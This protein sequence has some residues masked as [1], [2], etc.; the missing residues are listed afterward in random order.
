M[1]QP[2]SQSQ[3]PS[4][5]PTSSTGGGRRRLRRAGIAVAAGTALIVP[6]AFAVT[7]DH[8]D[9]IAE[10]L[11]A[12]DGSAVEARTVILLIGDGTGDSEITIAR[13]YAKGAAGQLALDTLPF[14]GAMTTYSVQQD[15][16]ELP[17]YV[18]D[19]AS[20]ATAW[21]TGEQTYNGAISVLPD[22][23]PT[24]TL[25]QLAAQQ[26]YLTGVVTTSEIQDAT[27]AVQYSHVPAR[28]CLGPDSMERC[29]DEDARNGGPGSISEQ[30]V[31]SDA[32]LI[33]GGGKQHLDQRIRGGADAGSTSWQVAQD[34]GFDTITTARELRR[35]RGDQPVLGVFGSGNLDLEWTGPTP[36]ATGTEP[37]QCQI[38]GAR[39]RNQPRLAEL[40][41]T[42]LDILHEQ[43]NLENADADAPSFGA[44]ADPEPE[45]PSWRDAAEETSSAGTTNAADGPG[46][47]LQIEGAS[48]DKQAH[49]ANPCGQIGET[50]EFDAAVQAALDYQEAFPDTLV[51]V[52]GDHSHTPQIVGAGN[53]TEGLTASLLT[54]D[55]AVMTVSYATSPEGSSQQH[56]GSQI[57]I[58]AVGPQSTNV[59][60]VTHQSEIFAT[61]SRALELQPQD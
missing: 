46:F 58:A 55:D 38:N 1:S 14:T 9:N 54:A 11:D 26:D 43:T 42:A 35:V 50:V 31:R 7:G 30:L 53:T 18:P 28:Q 47:F 61:I 13:N 40:T 6:T 8:Q 37:A 29:P 5:S 59:L 57:R 45:R 60:G 21:A 36:T 17:N 3:H 10:V 39:D 34:E 22:G 12:V 16:P 32:Y 20:T 27:P 33:F 48:I 56:T 2:T 51:I 25:L 15:D 41:E 49:A 4:P 24:P 52:T 44:V 23:T 19:S